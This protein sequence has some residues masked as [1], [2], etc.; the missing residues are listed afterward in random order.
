MENLIEIIKSLS[1]ITIEMTGV[2][3]QT[4]AIFKIGVILGFMLCLI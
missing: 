4:L 2:S 1:Q 3:N